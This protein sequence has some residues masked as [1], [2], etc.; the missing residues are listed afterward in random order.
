MEKCER[1]KTGGLIKGG[2][3]PLKRTAAD[4]REQFI[5]RGVGAVFS[6][7]FPHGALALMSANPGTRCCQVQNW[8]RGSCWLHSWAQWA[9][10][11]VFPSDRLCLNVTDECER[12]TYFSWSRFVFFSF[13]R[14]C[15]SRE[16]MKS[17][18]PGRTVKEMYIKIPHW[19][20]IQEV[21]QLTICRKENYCKKKP[22]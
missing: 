1:K 2:I 19:A 12:P 20:P 10:S 22:F 15:S 9:V 18:S 3:M 13:R 8:V 7:H 21:E 16:S 11:H 4:E 14:F 5:M 6:D 17:N